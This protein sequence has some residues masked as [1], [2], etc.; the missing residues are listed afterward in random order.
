MYRVSHLRGYEAPSQNLGSE[1]KCP[2]TCHGE[3]APDPDIDD[4]A[5]D[6][7]VEACDACDGDIELE[8]L[9]S[10]ND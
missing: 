4:S 1:I 10:A 6:S 3:N 7:L 2:E 9:Q 8:P 5:A